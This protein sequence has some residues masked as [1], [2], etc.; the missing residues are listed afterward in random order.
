[1]HSQ[2]GRAGSTNDL[3]ATI[4]DVDEHSRCTFDRF[5]PFGSVDPRDVHRIGVRSP[6]SRKVGDV[7]EFISEPIQTSQAHPTERITEVA[8]AFLVPTFHAASNVSAVT[9]L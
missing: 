5:E 4:S 9:P 3:N 6:T 7:V 8:F 2:R 1:M